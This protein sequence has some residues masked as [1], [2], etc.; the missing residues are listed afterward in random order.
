V[1]GGAASARFHRPDSGLGLSEPA[2]ASLQ[3]ARKLESIV[4]LWE[5]EPANE[6]LSDRAPNEAYL[7]A[8]PG[9]AYALYL[10]D[11]GT[12][13]LNLSGAN[14][15]FEVRWIDIGTGQW[16]KQETL[17][18]EQV[19]TVAAPGRGHWLAVIKQR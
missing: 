8:C 14:G 9:R 17:E 12:V 11:G 6:R 19:V 7:A 1:I 15:P 4:K 18:G 13:G 5:L 16:G 2:V 10:T 3:A